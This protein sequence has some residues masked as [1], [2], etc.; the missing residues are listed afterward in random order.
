M[1]NSFVKDINKAFGH[2]GQGGPAAGG[3]P[4]D[5]PG[6]D[7]AGGGPPGTDNRDPDDTGQ[8]AKPPPPPPVPK[9]VPPPFYAPKQS[10]LQGASYNPQS[11]SHNYLARYG[12]G[13][14]Y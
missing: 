13:G 4:E 7:N 2:A 6:S 1:G 8:P 5:W 12:A 10:Q 3:S 14:H 11:T 9:Y